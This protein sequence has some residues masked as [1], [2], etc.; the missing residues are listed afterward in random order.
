M[1]CFFCERSV[2]EHTLFR[3]NEKGV[4][5][6]WACREHMAQTDAAVDPIVREIADII[7]PPTGKK[8]S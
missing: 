5:G 6:I 4:K 2:H 7:D 3:V 1:K 8:P